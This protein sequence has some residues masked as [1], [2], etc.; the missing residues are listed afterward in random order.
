MAA[1]R[2]GDLAQRLIEDTKQINEGLK[3]LNAQDPDSKEELP[4]EAKEAFLMREIQKRDETIKELS[5]G[6]EELLSQIEAFEEENLRYA[7][8][9][10]NLR[11]T[12]K[13]LEARLS[14]LESKNAEL[15][16]GQ[17]SALKSREISTPNLDISDLSKELKVTS[18][19]YARGVVTHSMTERSFE[20]MREITSYLEQAAPVKRIRDGEFW[21]IAIWFLF[22]VFRELKDEAS[23][24]AMV[25]ELKSSRESSEV[26][27]LFCS[28]LLAHLGIDSM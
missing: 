12:I 21:N 10:E 25:D 6:Q 1:R 8:E 24:T 28:F 13:E 19:A 14:S 4:K 20:I 23:F 3:Q 27:L 15:V 18:Q 5:A 16:A 22:A 2:S 7:K 11:H 17:D 9:T 26:L